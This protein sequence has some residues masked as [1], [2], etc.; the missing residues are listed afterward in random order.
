MS[1]PCIASW[2]LAVALSLVALAGGTQPATAETDRQAAVALPEMQITPDPQDRAG[3]IEA[4]GLSALEHIQAKIREQARDPQTQ[5]RRMM[6]MG[7][8]PAPETIAE[9]EPRTRTTIR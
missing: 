5:Y 6:R 4:Q 3:G 1:L 2:P 7:L 8:I 9:S